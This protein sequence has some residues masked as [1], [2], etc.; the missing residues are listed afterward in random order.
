MDAD[1]AGSGRRSDRLGDVDLVLI[2]SI[3]QILPEDAGKVV[4]TGSHGGVSAAR[5]A[6]AVAARLYVFNDAGIGKQRA[7][8]AGLDRLARA[9][10]AACAVAHDTARIG[11][12]GDSLACGVV[13]AVNAPAAALGLHVGL[14]LRDQLAVLGR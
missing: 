2:D 1:T 9:G 3:T 13:S 12:A 4:V 8:I 11:E 7:G 5:F 14:R 6:A 10:I